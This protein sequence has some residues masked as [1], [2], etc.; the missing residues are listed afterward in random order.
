MNKRTMIALAVLTFGSVAS[1]GV[2][3]ANKYSEVK[4][5]EATTMICDG[6]IH[7]GADGEVKD[8]LLLCV[9]R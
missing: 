5:A 1:F 2:L 8:E 6:G 4:V 9:D 7:I 3:T